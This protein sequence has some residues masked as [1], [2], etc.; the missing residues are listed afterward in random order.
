MVGRTLAELGVTEDPTPR[1]FAVKESVL[2]FSR[3]PGVDPLLSPEMRSTGEVMGVDAT[4]PLAYAKSQVEAGQP[5]PDS[6]N[7]FISVKDADKD[8]IT[9]VALTLESLG[10]GI[11]ATSGTADRLRQAGVDAQL[12]P[13][14]AEGKRPNIL[15]RIK[16]ADVALLINTPSG[17]VPR[18]DEVTIRAA[19]IT[20]NIPLITT[21][22][23]AH[24]AAAAIKALREGGFE[25]HS[26]QE[27]H[28]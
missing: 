23:A 3:F 9:A 19:A 14:L 24:A 16:N 10:F 26:L 11:L 1:Y 15:D 17:P 27:I 22:A 18:R 6:G 4:F 5:L 13:K 8:R 12:V 2:P 28:G 25:V 7:V 20:Y 21:V